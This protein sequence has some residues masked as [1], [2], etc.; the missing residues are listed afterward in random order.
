MRSVHDFQAMHPL[1]KELALLAQEERRQGHCKSVSIRAPRDADELDDMEEQGLLTLADIPPKTRNQLVKGRFISSTATTVSQL[2]DN[3]H[4]SVG[5]LH[6]DPA[7]FQ[8]YLDDPARELENEFRIDPLNDPSFDVLFRPPQKKH[9]TS[10]PSLLTGVLMHRQK[11]EAAKAQAERE[12]FE[13]RK[14]AHSVPERKPSTYCDPTS[15]RIR[16]LALT[17]KMLT[18]ERLKLEASREREAAA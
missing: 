9:T 5:R 1:Y 12:A 4:S 11:A 3:L 2:G 17:Q 7:E 6:L 15:S 10:L 18:R 8:R 13:A 14:R 16:G